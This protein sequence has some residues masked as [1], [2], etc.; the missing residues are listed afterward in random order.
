MKKSFTFLLTLVFIVSLSAQQPSW[1]TYEETKP[2]KSG[3]INYLKSYKAYS[4]DHLQLNKYLRDEIPEQNITGRTRMIELPMP[5]GKL[6]HFQIMKSPVMEPELAAKYPEIQTFCGTDGINYIRI[7]ITPTSFKAFV[8]TPSGDVIIESV[9]PQSVNHYISYFASDIDMDFNLPELRCGVTHENKVENT[10]ESTDKLAELAQSVLGNR[11][12]VLRKLRIAI[13]CTG[14]WGSRS[15]L[16]GGTVASGLAKMAEAL[17]YANAVYEKDFAIHLDMVS[18]NDRIVFLDPDTDPYNDFESMGGILLGINSSV[19]NSRIGPNFYEFGHVFHTS[20]SDVGG[21]ASLS[22]VCSPT[23]KGAGVTCWYDPDVAYVAQR[24]FCHE[25]GHQFSAEHTFSNCANGASSQKYE[26][27]SGTTIMSYSGL[28]GATNIQGGGPPHPNFFHANSLQEVISFTRNVITCGVSENTSNTYPVPEILTK[29][30]LYL[31]ISTPFELKGQATDMEDTSLTYSWEQFDNG[32]YGDQLGAVSETGPLFKVLFPSKDPNRVLPNW[33]AIINFDNVDNREVLPRNTRNLTFRYVVRD[34]HPGAGGSSWEQLNLKVTEDA[35]P[36]KVSFPNVLADK[37]IKGVCNLITWDVANTNKSPVN[38]QKVD[39][40]FFKG[41]DYNN[42]IILKSNTENDGSEFVDIPN[43]LATNS[44]VRVIIKSADN[45]FFDISDIDISIVEST[46]P[47]VQFGVAPNLVNVCLPDNANILIKSCSFGGFTGNL[48]LFIESGLPQGSTYQFAKNNIGPTDETNLLINLNNLTSK[49]NF[50]VVIAAITP[51]GDTLRDHVIISAIKN[52][53]TDQKLVWPLNGSKNNLEIPYFKWVKSINADAYDFEIATSP[54]F[55]NTI[56]YSQK[57][58]LNDSI[59]PN[60]VLQENTIY[61]WRLFSSNFCGSNTASEISVFQTVNKKCTQVLYE[62]NP[63]DL[64]SNSTRSAVSTVNTSGQISD[65]NVN[66]VRINA[67]GVSDVSLT[68]ISPKGTRVNLFNYNCANSLDFDCSFD[69]EAVSGISCPPTNKKRMR[70]WE[71]LNK[72]KGEDV[73]GD[74]TLEATAKSTLRSI[75]RINNFEIEY[76]ADLNI[77]SPILIN[78]GPLQLN[79][80][81]TKVIDSPLLLSQD[82]DNTADQLT[83]TLVSPTNHGSLKLNGVAFPVLLSYGSTFTQKDIDSGK[84][85]YSHDGSS[86]KSDEFSF[87]VS[88]GT[89]GWLG[90]AVFK[91]NIGP[92]STKDHKDNLDILIYPN[93]SKGVLSIVANEMVYGNTNLKLMNSQGKVLVNKNVIFQKSTD[94]NLT[95]LENGIY[96]LELKNGNSK[97]TKKLILQK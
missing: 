40:L 71:K 57:G 84:I 33:N 26:P 10:Y 8:L 88:D 73:K 87:I 16:G 6:N 30:G 45:I 97:I 67:D 63:V 42:P 94:L 52:D 1:M 53:F 49:G 44:K 74:W 15:N 11:P 46:T 55:G 39:I 90:I 62:G 50:D 9:S 22:S 4:V 5:N 28:C 13:A 51:N 12:V 85:S 82:A 79:V 77:V 80:S 34:N 96:F 20:C 21:I 48:N 27:G 14:E 95:S 58:I 91:I 25:M 86:N 43:D 7:C 61:Y 65:V 41:R 18:G 35:G 69:D 19:T 3:T 2:L 70:A 76:C 78:N 37:L 23:G 72:F 92:V 24:I 59:R 32:P 38:C 64:F 60:I 17:T 93:P 75:G 68:L 81:E 66:N 47:K 89:G 54:T 31:P 36:F 83:Y 29:Q 56:V